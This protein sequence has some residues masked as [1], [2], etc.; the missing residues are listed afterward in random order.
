MLAHTKYT[1]CIFLLGFTV[2][3]RR[4]FQLL[5]IRKYSGMACYGGF[6]INFARND[7]CLFV[8]HVLEGTH[9]LL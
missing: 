6:A 2:C 3:L 4:E 7:I 5:S 8:G 1:A 9:Y